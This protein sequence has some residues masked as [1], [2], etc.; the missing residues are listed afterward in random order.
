MKSFRIAAIIFFVF[1]CSLSACAQGEYLKT[2]S[3]SVSK[4]GIATT[5]T[6]TLILKPDGSPTLTDASGE[7]RDTLD[8]FYDD[9]IVWT[10]DPTIKIL[11]IREKLTTEHFKEKPTSTN[12]W[13][14][15]VKNWPDNKRHD[16]PYSIKLKHGN[17]K[18]WWDPLIR[19][20]PSQPFK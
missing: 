11:K 3:D 12:N 14:G 19:I 1:I 13:H 16:A 6:I 17:G 5:Y 18:R 4:S 10:S 9:E 2:T 20:N 15:K 7:R 8:V